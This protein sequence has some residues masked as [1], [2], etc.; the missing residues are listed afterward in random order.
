MDEK[1]KT[2]QE[3]VKKIGGTTSALLIVVKFT[4]RVYRGDI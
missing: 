2:E 4:H 1:W 3:E